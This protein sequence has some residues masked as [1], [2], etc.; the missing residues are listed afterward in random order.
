MIQHKDPIV[1]NVGHRIAELLA[2]TESMFK[3][4]VKLTFIARNSDCP[5]GSQDMI[6]TSD[7]IA[8][9]IRALEIRRREEPH[10][11]P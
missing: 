6:V 2:E 7:S 4:G 11:H 3:P 10:A 1:E 9:A 8:E 5:D